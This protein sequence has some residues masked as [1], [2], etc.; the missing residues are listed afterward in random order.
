VAGS[1]ISVLRGRNAEL[2]SIDEQFERLVSGVGSVTLIEGG[3]G[4]GKSRLLT[5]VERIARRRSLR[6]GMG[7]A[8]FGDSIVEMAALMDALMGGE[9]PLI[10]RAAVAELPI[11]PERRYW[12]LEETQALLQQAALD[13]PLVIVI[14]DV[15]W[16]R[17][18]DGGGVRHVATAS[19]GSSDRVDPGQATGTGSAPCGQRDA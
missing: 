10:D 15:Q 17:Q 7:V 11:G 12:F 18:R 16:G 3:P 13:H 1:T 19:G 5:E 8:E 4:M 2:A 9:S 14:D 6:T